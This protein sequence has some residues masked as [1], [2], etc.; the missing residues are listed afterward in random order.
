MESNKLPARAG[1]GLRG[2]HIAELLATKPALDWLE[3][4][5]E[6]YFGSGGPAL[7]QLDQVRADYALSLHGV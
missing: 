5:S 2:P 4:H 1:I 7:R 3:V 6:N